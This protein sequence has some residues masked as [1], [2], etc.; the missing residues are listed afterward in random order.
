[1]EKV[2]QTSENARRKRKALKRK[3][4]LHEAEVVKAKQA[5]VKADAEARKAQEK[6]RKHMEN[7]MREGKRESKVTFTRPMTLIL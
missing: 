7:Q 5:T 4:S 2:I 1:M 3:A 6:F